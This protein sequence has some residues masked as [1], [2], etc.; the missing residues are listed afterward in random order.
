MNTDDANVFYVWDLTDEPD[1]L[2]AITEPTPLDLPDGVLREGWLADMI[3]EALWVTTTAV[4]HMR[5]LQTVDVLARCLKMSME[6]GDIAVDPMALLDMRSGFTLMDFLL[7]APLQLVLALDEDSECHA[8][9]DT[10]IGLALKNCEEIA[11]LITCMVVAARCKLVLRYSDQPNRL[12]HLLADPDCD[13]ET[14]PGNLRSCGIQ[15]VVMDWAASFGA[16]GVKGSQFVRHKWLVGDDQIAFRTNAIDS[17]VTMAD[18]VMS[19]QLNTL[20]EFSPTEQNA[21]RRLE[22]GGNHTWTEVKSTPGCMAWKDGMLWMIPHIQGLIVFVPWGP[23]ADAWLSA[24]FVAQSDF[25]AHTFPWASLDVSGE[26]VALLRPASHTEIDAWRSDLTSEQTHTLRTGSARVFELP[27]QALNPDIA[28]QMMDAF[29][30]H[31]PGVA[32]V[33]RSQLYTGRM[34]LDLMAMLGRTLLRNQSQDVAS[35]EPWGIAAFIIGASK[36]GKTTLI[37]HMVAKWFPTERIAFV[38]T[39]QERVFGMQEIPNADCVVLPDSS[40]PNLTAPNITALFSGGSM[41]IPRKRL[42]PLQ[43]VMAAR[44]I[45]SSNVFVSVPGDYHLQIPRVVVNFMF[46]RSFA[47]DAEHMEP[48]RDVALLQWVHNDDTAEALKDIVTMVPSAAHKAIEQGEAVGASDGGQLPLHRFQ[49]SAQEAIGRSGH[50]LMELVEQDACA[51]A[52]VAALAYQWLVRFCANTG[53]DRDPQA[54]L[55]W[56]AFCGAVREGHQKSF[57]MHPVVHRVKDVARR[58]QAHDCILTSQLV[59][60]AQLSVGV[61][62]FESFMR[63]AG[64]NVRDGALFGWVFKDAGC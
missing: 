28:G 60:R 14:I 57:Q 39:D 6:R 37:E 23:D 32:H 29:L 56:D 62:D 45:G 53:M 58:A 59:E 44:S 46:E 36:A 7:M 9:H 50:T 61:S 1:D 52:P 8:P 5:K 41:T 38:T 11:Q 27:P 13:L 31:L 10:C 40:T 25:T 51:A 24:A 22:E 20:D 43:V 48:E 49:A 47:A 21:V 34:A 55:P 3:D 42:E 19:I 4:E 35:W 15:R 63:M 26:T 16:I 33:L 18:A 54:H 64:F 17:L 30:E 2:I 12:C